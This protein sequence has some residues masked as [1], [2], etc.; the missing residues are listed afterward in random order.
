M[1]VLDAH[2]SMSQLLSGEFEIADGI[3]KDMYSKLK[4]VHDINDRTE[5]TASHLKEWIDDKTMGLH[6]LFVSSGPLRLVAQRISETFLRCG[7]D[8]L[9]SSKLAQIKP[10]ILPPQELALD[11][12]VPEMTGDGEALGLVTAK[13]ATLRPGFIVCQF[14][15]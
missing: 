5:E 10:F 15:V 4:Q 12:V 1:R 8:E 11:T 9:N 13:L 14:A 2:A 6:S 7:P 3:T